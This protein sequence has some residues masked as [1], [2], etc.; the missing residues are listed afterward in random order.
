MKI[1]IVWHIKEN[2]PAI[3]GMNYGSVC[4]FMDWANAKACLGNMAN[5]EDYKVEEFKISQ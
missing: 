5:P 4:A 3:L 2:R 1:Y